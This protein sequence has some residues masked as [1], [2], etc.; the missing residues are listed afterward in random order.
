MWDRRTLYAVVVVLASAW[1]LS[2]GLPASVQA[3]RE[4]PWD[5]KVDWQGAQAFKKHENPY[6]PEGF[7][8]IGSPGVGFGHPPTTPFWF[9]TTTDLDMTTMSQVLGL[10]VVC[11]LLVHCLI[12]AVELR[13]PVPFAT[14]VLIFA[15]VLRTSW[16][17]YHLGLAQ[18][19]ELIA[20][21]YVLSWRFLR[22]GNEIA[23][24][25]M[26]GFACTLKLF[27]GLM[28]LWLLVTGRWRAVAAACALWLPIA[29]YMT[30][31]FGL[32]S[33]H[34]FFGVQSAIADHWVC[35][36]ENASVYGI[37]LRMFRP[38]CKGY[39]PTLR[40]ATALATAVS[41]ALVALAWRLTARASR[42]TAEID[43]PFALFSVVSYTTNPWVWEHYNVFL[44]LPMALCLR[45][46]FAERRVGLGGGKLALGL[47]VLAVTG[48]LLSID[49]TLKMTL[50]DKYG[51]DKSLHR[52]VHFYEVA[53][54]LPAVLMIALV[55]ALAYRA[56]RNYQT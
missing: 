41:V 6:S 39:G 31:G 34:Q 17:R 49:R 30:T 7:R 16:M 4:H 56:E 27:P 36:I 21:S 35:H 32:V 44:I 10:L 46:L 43:L 14:G 40:A 55:G 5:G 9:L 45:T 38:V 8:A 23:A 24:G 26:L 11:A 19:S 47:L 3:L 37:A 1:L 50:R 22:R 12:V 48:Y 15:L 29:I 54:W 52:A 25:A 28:V 20:F 33:W 18:L 53:N 42:M 51:F 13:F 2:D